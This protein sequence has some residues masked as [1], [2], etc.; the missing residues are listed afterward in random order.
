MQAILSTV[1][2]LGC[3]RKRIFK[4]TGFSKNMKNTFFG[5]AFIFVLFSLPFHETS[6]MFGLKNFQAFYKRALCGHSL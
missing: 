5:N 3:I 4:G 2:N 1:T 6:T